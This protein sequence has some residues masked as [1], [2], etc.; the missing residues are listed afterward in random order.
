MPSSSTRTN[1]ER[2]FER[3][4]YGQSVLRDIFSLASSVAESGKHLGAQKIFAVAEATRIFGED[5]HELPHL[6][7]YAEAAADGLDDVGD[8]VDRTDM[9]EILDDMADYAKRQPIMTAALALAAGIALTQIIRN[10][11][12]LEPAANPKPRSRNRQEP[13]SNSR[14]MH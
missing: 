2:G 8:Y 1:G 5:L 7:A 10:W 11:R 12:T 4:A 9:P 3:R 6:Q 14:R 13:R